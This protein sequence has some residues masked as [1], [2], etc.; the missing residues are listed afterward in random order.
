M[1]SIIGRQY[2]ALGKFNCVPTWVSRFLAPGSKCDGGDGAGWLVVGGNGGE[3][4]SS[5]SSGGDSSWK[6]WDVVQV[7]VVVKWIKVTAR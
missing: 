5:G 7:L 3:V 1:K 2:L 6:R 4:C